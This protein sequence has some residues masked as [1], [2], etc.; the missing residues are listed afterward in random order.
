MS[1]PPFLE[2]Y[3][4]LLTSSKWNFWQ[5]AYSQVLANMYIREWGERVWR[6]GLSHSFSIPFLSEPL[7]SSGFLFIA[8]IID[9]WA[10]MISLRTSIMNNV[11][12][13]FHKYHI[14][15]NLLQPTLGP[16]S[17]PGITYSILCK[18]LLKC[19]QISLSEMN[20]IS[21]DVTL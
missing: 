17:F 7:G 9:M 20:N 11:E 10:S 2:S 12:E 21:S 13:D 18:P 3:S 5:T 4:F 1:C 16:L 14:Q 15:R 19:K 8:Q 6:E